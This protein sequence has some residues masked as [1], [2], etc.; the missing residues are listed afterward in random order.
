L[1]CNTSYQ[2]FWT[3]YTVKAAKQ[4]AQIKY[5]LKIFKNIKTLSC[6]TPCDVN[7]K[8]RLTTNQNFKNICQNKN[9]KIEELLI[10]RNVNGSEKESPN[11][12]ILRRVRTEK[13]WKMFKKTLKNVSAIFHASSS[14]NFSHLHIHQ[15]MYH[16]VNLK[17]Y[18][19]ILFV[20][21]ISE[22][23]DYSR[24]KI[25]NELWICISTTPVFIASFSC[26]WTLDSKNWQILNPF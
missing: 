14:L 15:K 11:F 4:L 2:M 18:I 6:S 7:Q 19:F 17:L 21:F 9:F 23:I 22:L 26:C 16:H 25:F 12:S 10:D 24:V 5:I 20:M 13:S 3:P 8:S 1:L